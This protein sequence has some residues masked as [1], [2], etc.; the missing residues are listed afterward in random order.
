MKETSFLS[1]LRS[2]EMHPLVVVLFLLVLNLVLLV[3]VPILF[4][5]FFL[6]LCLFFSLSFVCFPCCCCCCCL[7]CCCSPPPFLLLI[8]SCFRLSLPH[9]LF[10]LFPL[11]IPSLSLTSF[12]CI[13]LRFHN[14]IH[15]L[16]RSSNSD[17][18]FFGS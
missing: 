3:L 12:P 11:F 10:L 7:S 15:S 5:L 1:T 14:C 13:G 6:Y 8:P 4:F 9:L 18:D 2:S 16:F 17:L